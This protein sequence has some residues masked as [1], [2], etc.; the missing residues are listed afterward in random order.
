MS[1]SETTSSN[2]EHSE[3]TESTTSGNSTNHSSA[4]I[5]VETSSDPVNISS[6]VLDNVP[7]DQPSD[8]PPETSPMDDDSPTPFEDSTMDQHSSDSTIQDY[9][10]ASEENTIEL[11]LSKPPFLPWLLANLYVNTLPTQM[12]LVLSLKNRTLVARISIRI[13]RKRLDLFDLFFLF[14]TTRLS[15]T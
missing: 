9:A 13:V 5:P 3:N 8:Q 10:S 11:P 12:N 6:S 15:N 7:V 1:T 2:T 4:D 14:L